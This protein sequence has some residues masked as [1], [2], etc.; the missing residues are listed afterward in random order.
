VREEKDKSRHEPR[1][2]WGKIVFVT[3]AVL[4]LFG[5][6]L[7]VAQL[8]P[9]T[10]RYYTDAESIREP[11]EAARVR[12]I[13]WQP[14]RPLEEFSNTEKDDYEPRLS[15]DGMTLFFVRGKAGGNAEIMVSTKTFRQWTTPRALHEVNSE[16]DDLGPEPSPDGNALY[17]Y[18]D[19]RGG[20][21]GFDLW[22]A[23]RIN[24][25]WQPA[26]NL[27]PG[28]NSPYNDYGPAIT[29][30]GLSIYFA[31]NR[32]GPDDEHAPD[33]GA[34]P[35]TIR[36]E[37]HHRDYDLYASSVTDAGVGEA[38]PLTLLNTPHNEG[39]PAVSSFGDFLYFASDRPGGFGGFDL[40]RSWR[41]N[42]V[43]REAAN[44]G[45]SINT[46]A[47]ELDPG[48]SLGGYALY[49]SSD[50]IVNE[51]SAAAVGPSVAMAPVVDGRSDTPRGDEQPAAAYSLYY[52]TSREV[53][54]DADQIERAIVD[55]AAIW[56]AIWP[57]LLWALLA[58]LFLLALLWLL[59]DA[60]GRRLSL[61]AKCLLASLMAHLMLLLLFN[62][63][64]VTAS[65]AKEFQRRGRIQIA[66]AS[67]STA[68]DLARQIRGSLTDVDAPETVETPDQRQQLALAFTPPTEPTILDATPIN[69]D[70]STARLM[71]TD[72]RDSSVKHDI[73][74][75][76]LA[77]PDPPQSR[78][79]L[80]EASLPADAQRSAQVEETFKARVDAPS[81]PAD[82]P[83]V[84][85]DNSVA[86]HTMAEFLAPGTLQDPMP[87]NPKSLAR[88]FDAPD[89]Q[90]PRDLRDAEAPAHPGEIDDA[91]P[92][93]LTLPSAPVE[94]LAE[95]TEPTLHVAGTVT[96]SR[97]TPA[98]ALAGAEFADAMTIVPPP[99]FREETTQQTLMESQTHAVRDAETSD[100]A[101]APVALPT[102]ALVQGLSIPGL[103]IS[104]PESTSSRAADAE[105]DAIDVKATVTPLRAEFHAQ[106]AEPSPDSALV[107]MV[108]ASAVERFEIGSLADVANDRLADAVPLTDRA[109][110]QVPSPRWEAALPELAELHVPN[111]PVSA[112]ARPADAAVPLAATISVEPFRAPVRGAI[113]TDRSAALVQDLEHPQLAL[114]NIEGARFSEIDVPLRDASPLAVELTPDAPE[115]TLREVAPADWTL[116]DLALPE[117]QVAPAN[118]YLQRN[119][120]DR[121][122]IV[123]RMGGS[124]ETE[125]AVAN[126]LRWLA[127]HQSDD[128]RWDGD[129]FDARCGTCGGT[130]D[131]AVDNA[132]TGLALLTFYGAGHTHQDDGPY[133]E[134]TRRGLTWLLAQQ[135]P[136]GDLRGQ[137]TMYSHGIATIALSEAFGMT[138]DSALPAPVARAVN[139][140]ERARNRDSGGWRYD[141][142]Q[143]GDTSVLGWQVMALKSAAMNGIAVP[144]GAFRA[145]SEWMD[146]VSEPARP[147]L[148]SYQPGKPPTP[149]MTAE[150]MY[151][152][153]LLGVPREDPRMAASAEYVSGH[154][155]DWS[156]SPNTYYWYY[157][158][159]ALFHHRGPHWDSWNAA[160]TG[161]LLQNQRKDGRASGSWDP[162][163]E[164]ANIGGRI[165]QTA[166]C[167][168]MLEVYYRYLPLY[169]NE[170]AI[171][172][173]GAIRGFVTD[174]ES[175]APLAG[176]MV[177]LDL[178]DRDALTV[179]TGSDGAFV[180]LPPE[181]PDFFA[182]SASRPGYVPSSANVSSA[183]VK[184]TTLALDFALDPQDLQ[185][186]AIE[187]AP[188]VHHLGDDKF[189]GTINSQF[190]KQSEGSEFAAEFNLIA[191]QVPPHVAHAEVRLLAKGVQRRH[192]IRINGNRLEE[193]LDNAPSDGSFGEFT[194]EFD[195]EWLRDGVNRFELIAQ[196]SEVDIDDFEFVNV[197]I[198]IR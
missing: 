145:A 193:R 42:G 127:E 69:V 104:V 102:T 107:D 21:G 24:N 6:V 119:S 123:E 128:G 177:R 186:V 180:L 191:T 23:H 3:L 55:W 134:V 155:P 149:S 114:A 163:G 139:F 133:R 185:T 161:E 153:Q 56:N 190:Q 96:D 51:S 47:N 172:P 12:D 174:A 173:I 121:L 29:P 72:A 4:V 169:S 85:L 91:S 132:L 50:R 188:Q 97:I 60:R 17:F 28:V 64:E 77:E 111:M 19:R 80:R 87:G 75:P 166:L 46:A 27:G 10:R 135:K 90:T 101:P 98:P 92:A 70:V 122:A 157:A 194:A 110:S 136:D 66:L 178:P 140:I 124:E 150:G 86:R 143:A 129:G 22:I 61:L 57:H 197:R 147:G 34:W 112:D 164:W 99:Q 182:L 100:E 95:T 126:A 116:F 83:S 158:T 13:L 105:T 195:P 65:L 44:L 103:Q 33:S 165:Y 170:A 73:E 82:R 117:D 31:S 37:F 67:P 93:E 192:T 109:D 53:F 137:E 160:L 183:K 156:T 54:A 125:R 68:V 63:W 79:D 16:F 15:A 187:A 154:P 106:T 40:Y 113:S 9:V 130:T 179:T 2:S 148:Y 71:Q 94:R 18:S 176:A 151:V 62:V 196:P 168:L 184:G 41:I 167:T 141:P 20:F 131:V 7:A 30:D 59:R 152:Q 8:L 89:A 14:P 138:Q 38:R 52:S 189:E 1:P 25:E 81:T 45:H 120:P 11:I 146:Q 198:H 171:D 26:L 74:T 162:V 48:L 39:A 175:G 142:G 118:P 58:A 84:T 88:P 159:L 49:F 43:L 76:P 144:T 36:E 108:P 115:I 181:V 32:P 35:A 5:M 78:D